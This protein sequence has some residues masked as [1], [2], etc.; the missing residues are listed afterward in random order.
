MLHADS[1]VPRHA[2]PGFSMPDMNF[3]TT[4]LPLSDRLVVIAGDG[5]VAVLNASGR[6]LWEALEAGCTVDELVDASVREGNLAE[7][8]ARRGISR[9]LA[10]WHALGLIDSAAREPESGPVAAPGVARPAG[11]APEL[12]EVYLVGDR[13]VRV[14]SDDPVLAGVIAAACRSCRVGPAADPLAT[15]DVIE[16]HGRFAVR[17][18][19]AVLA[20]TEQLADN[21]ALARHR[22]LTALL[23]AARPAR[24]WLGILHASAVAV[25]GRCVVFCGERG[26]GKSTLA[27]ALVAAGAE[28]VTDDYAPLEQASWRVWP[29]P[30][31]PGIKRGSWRTLRR[32]YPDLHARPVHKLAGLQIRYLDLDGA[33]VAPLDRGLPVAALVFP[34]H[35]AG[36]RLRQRRITPAEAFAKLCR[37]RSLLDRQPQVL[38]E[39]LRWVESVPAYRLR[40]GDLD[41]AIGRVWSL[42]GAT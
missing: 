28:F 20:R 2:G 27:A 42:L 17:A 13:P 16:Q 32:R 29:V 9:A 10:S 7:D 19:D 18:D 15:V 12:D 25:D 23:E 14:R 22:C 38:A 26:A 4:A 24:R 8:A 31:A 6:R 41:A 35:E 5:T 11:R 34:R 33:R 40:Y 36:A 21:R 3:D 1:P 39:T 37:A 30:F